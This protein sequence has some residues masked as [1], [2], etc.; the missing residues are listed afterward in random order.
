V[1]KLKQCRQRVIDY[2]VQ[3]KTQIETKEVTVGIDAF[4]DKIVRVVHSKSTSGE[5]EF[6]GDISQFGKHL[7]TKSGMSCGIEVCERFTKL[8]GNAPIMANALGSLGLKVNCPAAL[9]Y[10]EIDPIFKDL[11]PNCR[12]YTIGNP[13]YTTALEFDDGKIMLSQRDYLHKI[14]WAVTKEML[15]LDTIRTLFKNSSLIGLVN[16]NGMVNFNE[17]FKG[18]LD[19]VLS[20]KSPNKEQIVFFDLA[21]FSER[22][23]EDIAAAVKLINSFNK[24]C[25]VIL[26]LNENEV[27]LMYKTLFPG[28]ESLDLVPMSQFIFDNISVDALVIHTLTS[29]MAFETGKVVEVPSL[30][31]KKPKLSTGGGD[32]FNAGLCFGQLMGLDFEG[33]LYTANATSGYYVRNAQSPTIDTL[34]ETLENW[35]NLIEEP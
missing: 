24:Y 2:L 4:V 26:G 7:V 32:N 11:S 21:D 3:A 20:V 17:I 14:N 31:V 12:L 10:P 8:G 34:I 30:Y 23:P 29:S 28:K 9:G 35:D 1:I 22:S 6:F 33:S 15:G 5:Y 18:I 27:I 16:W 25:K 19:E 13:G